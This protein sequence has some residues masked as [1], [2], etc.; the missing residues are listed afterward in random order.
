MIVQ[1]RGHLWRL[2]SVS[3]DTVTETSL[4]NPEAKARTFFLPFEAAGISIKQ[5]GLPPAQ[6]GD[7][8]VHDLF[9]RATRMTMMHGTAPLAS[10]QRSRVIPT[11]YQLVPVMMALDMPRVR[12]LIAVSLGKPI[13]AGLIT[14]ELL[15]RKQAGRVLV[16]TPANLREQWRDAFDHFFHVPL[17]LLST[18][19]IRKLGRRLP[20][21]ANP[22]G[23]FPYVV[24]S[25][26]YAKHD[27][28][29][30]LILHQ[31]WDLVIVDEAHGSAAPALGARGA[32]DKERYDFVQRLARQCQ[33]LILATATPHN[34]YSASFAS[35]LRMLDETQEGNRI[36]YPLGLVDGDVNEPIIRRQRA[37]RHI[38]QRRRKD[39][40]DW[41]KREHK[42]SPFP[43]RNSKEVLIE[44]SKPELEAD[45]ISGFLLKQAGAQVPY[46]GVLHKT[47]EGALGALSS[48]TKPEVFGRLVR[49]T[50]E[51]LHDGQEGA[52]DKACYEYLLTYENQWVHGS[53]DRTL[54]MP[55]LH[56]LTGVM[57]EQVSSN[58]H[59]DRHAGALGSGGRD[60]RT[61]QAW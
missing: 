36:S 33:H 9:L 12:L 14:L 17:E 21:G 18:S 27:T 13:E 26:D 53:L 38:V 3:A 5:M 57:W 54:I 39:V 40:Q 22:W 15:A 34:G 25:I 23:H 49:R 7:S 11:N 4:D 59:F 56:E 45:E 31:N 8:V 16:L 30:N 58:D 20:P 46:R 35:L 19:E 10:L 29:K 44:P 6:A 48:L 60:D 24:A 2:D 50:L 43:K 51:L 37:K 61:P 42:R 41:F 55:L 47:S 28:V 52:C 1:A 32:A